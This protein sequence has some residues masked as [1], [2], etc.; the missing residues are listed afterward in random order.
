MREVEDPRYPVA[1]G[2]R[3]GEEAPDVVLSMI[4]A[5]VD[6]GQ[7]NRVWVVDRPRGKTE[8]TLKVEAVHQVNDWSRQSH[9]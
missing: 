4:W 2:Q 9:A 5:A 3:H 6:V 8:S 7:E 1:M